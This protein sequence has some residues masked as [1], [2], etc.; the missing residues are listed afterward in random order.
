MRSPSRRCSRSSWGA[1]DRQRT[2]RVEAGLVGSRRGL[3]ARIGIDGHNH[4]IHDRCALP[5]RDDAAG[6]QRTLTITHTSRFVDANA[7]G[8]SERVPVAVV[9]TSAGHFVWVDEE[10]VML[11]EMKPEE[12]V[13]VMMKGLDKAVKG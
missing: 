2:Q 11:G 1:N 4:G 13:D 3:A 6:I 10:G 5:V 9:R 12:A 8:H 7:R